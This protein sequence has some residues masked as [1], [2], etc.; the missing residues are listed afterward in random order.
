M[1]EIFV[2]ALTSMMAPPTPSNIMAPYTLSRDMLKMEVLSSVGSFTHSQILEVKEIDNSRPTKQT[3]KPD[4]ADA[5]GC[6]RV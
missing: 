5:G 2:I 1:T 3:T 4:S 6:E